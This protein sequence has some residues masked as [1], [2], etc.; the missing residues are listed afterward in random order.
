DRIVVLRDGKIEQI[1]RPLDL[2]DRPDNLFVAGF[3]GSPAMNFLNGRVVVDGAEAVFRA[4]E[5]ID[6]PLK[7]RAPPAPGTEV[8]YGVR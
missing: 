2:Y 5:G 3:I 4:A 1:G 6:L 7:A 8:V